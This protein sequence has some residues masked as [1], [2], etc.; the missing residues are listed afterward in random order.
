MSGT[1][2]SIVLAMLPVLS[3]LLA[4]AVIS[5]DRASGLFGFLG[6]GGLFL[7]DFALDVAG[8]IVVGAVF[9]LPILRRFRLFR[10]A[11]GRRGPG[12]H[13]QIALRE[14]NF[15]LVLFQRGMQ[16]PVV[17]RLTAPG[18]RVASAVSQTTSL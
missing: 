7:G 1:L 14:R 11:L 12:P 8:R 4:R 16:R 15:E 9:P 2:I 3:F 5:V 17:G 18:R 6:F 10:L 13:V